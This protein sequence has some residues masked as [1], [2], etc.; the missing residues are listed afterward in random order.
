MKEK[1]ELK[2]RSYTVRTPGDSAFISWR[3]LGTEPDEIAFK[4]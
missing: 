3:L 4:A 1:G 2:I